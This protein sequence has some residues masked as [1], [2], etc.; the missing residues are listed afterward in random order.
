MLRVVT[1]HGKHFVD[2]DRAGIVRQMRDDAW[3]RGDPKRDYMD[4]V[5]GR[6]L[7]QTGTEIRVTVDG[8]IEDLTRLGY[9]EETQDD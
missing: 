3:M 7:Q 9:I 1:V 6:V 4:A 5:R 8:F 2:H